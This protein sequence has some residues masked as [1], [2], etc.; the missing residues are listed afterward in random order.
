[1]VDSTSKRSARNGSEA[2]VP[3][4][5]GRT[6]V[7]PPPA[8]ASSTDKVRWSLPFEL[9][10]GTVAGVVVAG[11]VVVLGTIFA[12]LQ[13]TTYVAESQVLLS[14]TGQ[15]EGSTT[16]S[17]FDTLSNGQLPET[18]AAIMRERRFLDSAVEQ[19]DLSGDGIS[20]TVSVVPETSVIR[21]EVTAGTPDAAVA[22]AD[23][24]PE[25]AQ[26]VV[27][28]LLAPYALTALGSAE[29]TVAQ[30]SVSGIQ[31]LVVIAVAALVLGAAVQQVV[32]QLSRA[33]RGRVT[34]EQA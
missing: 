26:A 28:D 5:G 3:A 11:V 16:S 21:V 22:V 6:P 7:G 24:V 10:T 25:E 19:L 32:Q 14:P 27:D 30:S 33:R 18:A 12:L 1:V 2:E 23:R 17:Y 13:P 34:A 8:A 29:T 31:W 20:S 15:D 4:V 9:P